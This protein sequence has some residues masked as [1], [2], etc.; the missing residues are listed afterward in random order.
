[1]IEASSP[2]FVM[3]PVELI[4]MV[5]EGSLTKEA[6]WLYVALLSHHNRHRRDDDVWPSRAVL[7]KEIGLKK[8]DSVDKYLDELREA[9][10]ITSEQRRRV[11]NMK[12]SSKHTLK[13]VVPRSGEEIAT[14]KAK[15]ADTPA[16]GYRTPRQRGTDTPATGDELEELEPQELKDVETNRLT[17]ARCAP[18][19]ERHEDSKD[20]KPE[21]P[22][23]D[24]WD[25]AESRDK[26]N[27]KELPH[28]R[29]TFEDWRALD[30]QTFQE[31]V[32][33]ALISNGKIWKAGRYTAKQFYN[34]FRLKKSGPKE[35]PGQYINQIADNQGETGVDDWL[36]SNGLERP[37]W[38]G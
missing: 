1:V 24:P 22:W 16:S 8:A 10:L 23:S 32:G 7:A 26:A 36:I 21:D 28:Q 14:R 20:Q 15:F 17:A 11:G 27:G 12:T 5:S 13:L 30:R 19:G 18:D 2:A 6:A 25:T 34:G 35:W 29:A 38:Q 33:N 37:E 3:V 4:D 9:H 31:H